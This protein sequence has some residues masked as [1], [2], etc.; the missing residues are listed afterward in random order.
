[1]NRMKI[2]NGL[3]ALSAVLFALAFSYRLTH[4]TAAA[5]VLYFL[6]Q[7]AFIGCAADWFAVSALFRKPLGFPFHT[8]LIPRHRGRIIAGIR[9]MT[10]E[11]LLRPA[12][13]DALFET[14]SVS[15][16]LS[17]YLETKTG[18]EAAARIAE[19]VKNAAEDYAKHHADEWAEAAARGVSVQAEAMARRLP[20][21]LTEEGRIEKRLAELLAAAAKFSETEDAHRR[22]SHALRD[23]TETQKGN[24]LVAMAISM[25][26]AMGLIDYDDMARALCAAAREKIEAWQK[27]D[28]AEFK[29]ISAHFGNALA[30]C[31]ASQAGEEA[32]R[33]ISVSFLENLNLR[34]KAGRTAEEILANEEKTGNAL[35][36]ATLQTI[37]EFLKNEETAAALDRAVRNLLTAST[38]REHSLLGETVETVLTGYDEHRLNNFIYTRTADELGWIR[39]NGAIVAT[40]AGGVVYAVL[41]LAR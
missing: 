5:S 15:R 19:D 29:R 18:R 26:E 30:A 31:L 37:S 33:T 4:E 39:I 8:A 32:L 28:S 25:G 17:G 2:A 24:P 41:L 6:T 7:S 10:E 14:F 11:K 1:M 16:W 3:F 27:T 34:E 22:A 20:A 21:I 40:I 23:F 12:L 35:R 36:A 13:W 38:R 9:R